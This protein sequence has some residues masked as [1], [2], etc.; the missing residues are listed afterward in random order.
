MRE[1]SQSCNIDYGL[2]LL[3]LSLSLDSLYGLQNLY[4]QIQKCLVD[5]S[6]N[7][8]E[9]RALDQIEETKILLLVKCQY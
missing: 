2:N 3:F 1:N 4:E 6:V 8:G 7:K 5:K 9:K